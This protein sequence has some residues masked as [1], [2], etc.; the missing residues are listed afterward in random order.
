MRSDTV[1]ELAKW[2][3]PQ[4]IL[5]ELNQNNVIMIYSQNW[6][7]VV[8]FNQVCDL[9][10]YSNEGACLGLDLTQVKAESDMSQ[11]SYTQAQF[12]GL[13]TMSKAAAR[14]INEQ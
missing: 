1:K 2:D 9:M 11:R 14:T 7:I 5:D 12:N 4:H 3:A 6:P 8:W 10:R 13:R